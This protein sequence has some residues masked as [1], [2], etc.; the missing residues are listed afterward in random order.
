MLFIWLDHLYNK[1]AHLIMNRSAKRAKS[2]RER[3]VIAACGCMCFCPK[4]NDILN[5]QA[6]W[7]NDD[8][9]DGHGFYSCLCGHIS[10]WHF[11]IAPVPILLNKTIKSTEK[12]DESMAS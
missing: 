3:D 4:C 11:G 10:E 9:D 7:V 1:L 8:T 5:D 2:K 12:H 6:E